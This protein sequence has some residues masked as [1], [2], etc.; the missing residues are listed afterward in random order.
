MHS[1]TVETIRQKLKTSFAVVALVNGDVAGCVFYQPEPTHV[2]LGRLSVLPRYRGR[3]VGRALIDYVEARAR[4][5]G[6]PRV[7]I[8][9]RLSL[10]DIQAYYHRL[11]YRVVRHAA[12]EGYTRPTSVVM[13]KELA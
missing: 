13:E 1:E 8:G 4:T 6:I 11:G 5:L 12:H 3:G 7:Q 10:A 2:Y 9:V